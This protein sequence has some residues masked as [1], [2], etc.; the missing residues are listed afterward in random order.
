MSLDL[1]LVIGTLSY[2]TVNYVLFDKC[3]ID[4]LGIAK[5]AIQ[6]LIHCRGLWVHILMQLRNPHYSWHVVGSLRKEKSTWRLGGIVKWLRPQALVCLSHFFIIAP[7]PGEFLDI[8]F[9]ANPLLHDLLTPLIYYMPVCLLW[10]LGGAHTMIM[11]K[12]FS[13]LRTD[14]HPCWEYR[15]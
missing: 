4:K 13:L 14:F 3:I 2:V 9:L 7:P 10:P 11:F 8:S 1:S 15:L 12:I 5:L 6:K